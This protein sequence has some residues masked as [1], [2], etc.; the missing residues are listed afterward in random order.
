MSSRP[1]M[2]R[3]AD[4]IRSPVENSEL[5]LTPSVNTSVI[6]VANIG[7]SRPP[8]RPITRRMRNWMKRKFTRKVPVPRNNNG[9]RGSRSSPGRSYRNVTNKRVQQNLGTI[10]RAATGSLAN[11]RTASVDSAYKLWSTAIRKAQ[12]LDCNEYANI[13]SYEVM[14]S[15]IRGYDAQIAELNESFVALRK[16]AIANSKYWNLLPEFMRETRNAAN[17]IRECRRVYEAKLVQLDSTKSSAILAN[18]ESRAAA[19]RQ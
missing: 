19:L 9:S 6:R 16:G 10:T 1:N 5:S 13:T 4:P 2:S 17:T 12:S 15:V 18:L 14:Q 8:K 3:W 11:A 7:S